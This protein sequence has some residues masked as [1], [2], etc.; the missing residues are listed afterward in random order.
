VL[1][2]KAPATRVTADVAYSASLTAA[3]LLHSI[4]LERLLLKS[5]AQQTKR[6]LCF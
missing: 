6:L 2:E 4:S 3:F 1:A 5:R